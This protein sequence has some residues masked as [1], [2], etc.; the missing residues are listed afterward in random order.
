MRRLCPAVQIRS[1]ISSLKTDM[2]T[3]LCYCAA[4]GD[5]LGLKALLSSDKEHDINEWVPPPCGPLFASR[6]RRCADAAALQERLRWPP[7]SSAPSLSAPRSVQHSVQSARQVSVLDP[8]H[9][10]G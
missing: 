2:V 10:S 1:H 4:M 8:F 3:K 9:G 7:V 6:R 5:V